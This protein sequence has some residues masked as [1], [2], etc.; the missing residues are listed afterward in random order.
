ML[1]SYLG[2]E[3]LQ[4]ETRPIPFPVLDEGNVLIRVKAFGLNRS[5]VFTR[6]G[7]SPSVEFPRILGIE[8]VGIL[9]TKVPQDSEF[10][11]GDYVAIAMGG[12]GRDFDGSY[13]EYVIVPESQVQLIDSET[14]LDWDVL[15]ALPELLQTSW[16]SLIKSLQ[17][18]SGDSLL[19][20][21]GTTSV[22][23]AA[24]AIA[25]KYGALFIAST[26]RKTDEGTAALLKKSG[27]D[28]VFIDNGLINEEVQ[29]IRPGGFDKVLELVGTTTLHDS[30]RCARTPGG[31]VS[32]TGIVGNS[33]KLD[34]F[35]PMEFIPTGVC[36]TSYSGS[37]EVSHNLFYSFFSFFEKAKNFVSL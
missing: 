21:G 17:F 31:I 27:A 25:K 16:G 23:L 26:T 35:N 10:E 13:A 3:A 22:G 14:T 37:S 4:I 34:D 24:A 2:P 15:G 20:R 28:H 7:H 11:T 19:I 12:M 30:L 9:E 18:K 33:W 32:M 6:Q 5:E 29:K 36:L 1:F 8:A